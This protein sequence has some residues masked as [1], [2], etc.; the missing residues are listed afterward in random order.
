MVWRAMPLLQPVT[1]T[2][3]ITSKR[4]GMSG[5]SPWPASQAIALRSA[6]FRSGRLEG[7]SLPGPET[8]TLTNTS[9]PSSIATTLENSPLP[10]S[11]ISY[12]L[13]ERIVSPSLV[14]ARG[15]SRDRAGQRAEGAEARG[16]G[17]LSCPAAAT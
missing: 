10:V 9:V 13:R 6:A 2:T 17:W 7:K 4:I 15:A 12:P 11:T 5:R 14:A 3:S 1:A 8:V 16:S